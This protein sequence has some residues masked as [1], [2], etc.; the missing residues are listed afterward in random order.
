[1]SMASENK[2][3]LIHSAKENIIPHLKHKRNQDKHYDITKI[4][5]VSISDGF[6][7][8]IK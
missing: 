3:H 8:S 5:V 7:I 6:R 4:I 1:M 2:I